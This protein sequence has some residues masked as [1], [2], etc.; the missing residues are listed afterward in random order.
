MILKA[1][2]DAQLISEDPRQTEYRLFGQVT[3]ALIDAKRAGGKGQP[4]YHAI[5]WNRRVWHMLS[6]DCMDER[7]RLPQNVRA[8]IIS[9]SMWVAK[10]SRKVLRSGAPLDPLIDVNRSVMQG[11]QEAA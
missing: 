8:Q 2:Q 5:D 10:Y 1:Y 7:N 6:L 3:G 4:L 11:L 9:L